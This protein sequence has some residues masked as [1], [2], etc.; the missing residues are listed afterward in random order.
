MST[1]IETERFRFN[2]ILVGHR[3]PR[4]T[5]VAI[6]F[7][8]TQRLSTQKGIHSVVF[9][10]PSHHHHHV[11]SKLLFPQG[12]VIYYGI[13]DSTTAE[14]WLLF[15]LCGPLWPSRKIAA[16][17]SEQSDAHSGSKNGK[18]FTE[19]QRRIRAME[20]EST[21]LSQTVAV[22]RGDHLP[23]NIFRRCEFDEKCFRW[24]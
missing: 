9:S 20:N 16:M 10:H 11:L 14:W 5:T 3:T 4:R 17:V 6:S 12:D 7:C 19:S 24:N 1:T 13:R 22:S 18:R 23:S 8:T 15:R 2:E 21:T